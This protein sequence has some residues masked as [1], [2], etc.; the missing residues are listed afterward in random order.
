[1]K[2]FTPS[3]LLLS[4]ALAFSSCLKDKCYRTYS[5]YRPVYHTTTEVR[6]N[7]KSNAP[8]ALERPGKFFVFGNYIFLNEVDKGVHLIDNTNSSAPKNVAFIDI[9]GN[10]DL[11]VK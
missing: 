5:I 7:I 2:K 3:L 9:P 10:I 4:F 6:A 11:A 8:R 1:M